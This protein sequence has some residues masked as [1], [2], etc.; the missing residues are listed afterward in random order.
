MEKENITTRK[1]EE[2]ALEKEVNSN[3]VDKI[4]KIEK[5]KTAS[6]ISLM[7][8][9]LLAW[10]CVFLA[11]FTGYRMVNF[12][13]EKTE[14]VS[15]FFDG[16]AQMVQAKMPCSPRE[17]KGMNVEEAEERL[18]NA[19]FLRIKTIESK[20]V[21]LGLLAQDKE[22]KYVTVYGDKTFE[23]DN[24]Y[25]RTAEIT[26][27]YHSAK[28]NARTYQIIAIITCIITATAIFVKTRK[29]KSKHKIQ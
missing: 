27:Y 20:D 6:A 17:F 5:W 28:D 16:I 23:K 9:K 10:L 1:N 25:S 2:K 22:V 7:M 4:L 18:K 26:I 29:N 12:T 15:N 8:P 11:V 24:N 21:Y 3:N 13:I 19:G 14:D